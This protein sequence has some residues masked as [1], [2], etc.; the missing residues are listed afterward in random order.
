MR[1]PE[2][3][4]AMLALHEKGWGTR[5]ID[6]GDGVLDALQA[7]SVVIILEHELE[8]VEEPVRVASSPLAAY[9]IASVPTAETPPEC[10]AARVR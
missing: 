8:R 7:P 6:P 2:E 1:E 10:A 5:R 4:A 3:V 9:N